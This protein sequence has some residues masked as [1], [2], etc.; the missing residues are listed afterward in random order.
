MEEKGLP[1]AFHGASIFQIPKPKKDITS[2]I[3]ISM[4]Q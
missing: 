2:K 4:P 3:C 1:Y